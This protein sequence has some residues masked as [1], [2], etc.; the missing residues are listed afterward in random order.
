VAVTADQAL[1]LQKEQKA[2]RQAGVDAPLLNAR[3]IASETGLAAPAAIRSRDGATIDPYRATVGLTA[4]AAARGA[5]IFE[6][7]PVTRVTF[8]RKTATVLSPGGAIRT[9]RVVV[10]TGSP[11]PLFKALARH[12]WFR[13]VFFALTAPVPAKVRAQLGT[14]RSVIRDAAIPPHFIRWIEDQRL[15]V[16][17]ADGATAPE[18]LRDKTIVQRTGQLMYELSTLYPEISGIMPEFGWESPYTRTVDGLP[19]IGAHRNYPH[20]VFAFGDSSHGVTGAYLAS[21]IFLRHHLGESDP[22]DEVFGFNR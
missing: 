14:R 22:A 7:S 16:A 13:S 1:R 18:R 10:A 19:Y 5:A 20:H 3:A 21:R 15:M 11:T 6:R 8:D 12:F 9:S 17:G 2:R 4:A